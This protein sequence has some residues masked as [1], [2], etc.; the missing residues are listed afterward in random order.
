MNHVHRVV[1]PSDRRQMVAY[2]LVA[3]LDRSGTSTTDGSS[4]SPKSRSRTVSLRSLGELLTRNRERDRTRPDSIVVDEQHEEQLEQIPASSS[5]AAI[6]RETVSPVSQEMLIAARVQ[7][8]SISRPALLKPAHSSP[9]AGVDVAASGSPVLISPHHIEEQKPDPF[10]KLPREVV[11]LIFKSLVDLHAQEH[12]KEVD[13][14]LWQGKRAF[15]TRW[16]GT[17]AGIR[18]LASLSRVSRTWQGYVL[19]GQLWQSLD[20]SKYPDMS[21][22]AMMRIAKAAGPFVRRLALQGLAGLSSSVVVA[23][24]EAQRPRPVEFQLSR[25][26]WDVSFGAYLLEELDLTG[27]QQVSTEALNTLISSTSKLRRARL[28]GLRCVDPMTLHWLAESHSNLEMLDISRCPMID[29]KDVS[30]MLHR[31]SALRL[32]REVRTDLNERNLASKFRELHAAGVSGFE[33]STLQQMGKEWPN[34]EVLDL[35]YCTDINDAAVAA[36]VQSGRADRSPEGYFVTLTPRQAGSQQDD[37]VVRRTFPCLKRLNLSGCR[38][39]TDRACISLAHAVPNLEVLELANIGPAIKD[40]G[41]VKLFATVPHL[42][43]LD[44]ERATQITDA[45]LSAITLRNRTVRRSVG[46]CRTKIL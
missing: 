25:R 15:E 29:G 40:A 34:L 19:D 30:L 26:N 41:L 31:T 9:R 12:R 24:T 17:D 33:A 8:S 18:E 37:E 3:T 22:D 5:A 39:L 43:K 13:S 38:A 16:C 35:S 42:Q 6:V 23:L 36:L 44:L 4:I 11:L 46:Q 27:C 21:E 32:Q 28:G 1:L 2:S 10:V 14:G 7:S 20:F 45:V